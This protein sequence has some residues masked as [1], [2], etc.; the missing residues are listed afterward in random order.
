[1][2]SCSGCPSDLRFSF[3]VY[4]AQTYRH[5]DSVQAVRYCPGLELLFSAGLDSQLMTWKLD[6]AGEE[7]YMNLGQG[8][9]EEG[10]VVV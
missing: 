4:F 5:T 7:P 2:C 8:V 3:M 9:F 1:M 6:R 10:G